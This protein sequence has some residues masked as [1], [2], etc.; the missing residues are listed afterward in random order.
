MLSVGDISNIRVK[1]ALSKHATYKEILKRVCDKILWVVRRFPEATSATYEISPLQTGLQ[2][3]TQ[4]VNTASAC[5][6]VTD[7][8]EKR[9][10]SV[11]HESMGA[12]VKLTITW[13]CDRYDLLNKMAEAC[14]NKQD[15]LF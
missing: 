14:V 15:V 11:E 3:L 7:K 5:K 12:L 13:K 1:R 6:Y 2:N 4:V 10:F 9:G 8:L